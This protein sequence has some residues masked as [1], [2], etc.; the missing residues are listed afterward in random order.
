MNQADTI[1]VERIRQLMRRR[2]AFAK[3]KM[4]GGVAFMINANMCVGDGKNL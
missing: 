3:Q 2:K 1:L 4:F